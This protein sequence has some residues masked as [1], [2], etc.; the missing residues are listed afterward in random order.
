VA[1]LEL[2]LGQDGVAEGLGGD[3]GAVGRGLNSNWAR[4]ALPKVSAVMPVPSETKKTVRVCIGE[5]SVSCK[6]AMEATPLQSRQLSEFSA[7]CPAHA[8]KNNEKA[9]RQGR[10]RCAR[11]QTRFQL[12]ELPHVCTL[13]RD[14]PGRSV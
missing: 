7:P 14:R 5:P 11:A 9:C 12:L 6:G 4:M 3:A 2:E 10:V 13:Q 1:R 8:S